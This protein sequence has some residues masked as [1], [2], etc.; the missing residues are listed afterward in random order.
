LQ[1]LFLFRL[2]DAFSNQS[3]E[4]VGIYSTFEHRC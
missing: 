1:R 2:D 4:I 3:P